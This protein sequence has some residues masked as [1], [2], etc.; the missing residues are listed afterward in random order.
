M[1]LVTEVYRQE[2]QD[3]IAFFTFLG[4]SGYRCNNIR[5]RTDLK[6]GLS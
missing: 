3:N 2:L 4:D 6:G 1:E 5:K